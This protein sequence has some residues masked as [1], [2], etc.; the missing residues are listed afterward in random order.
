MFAFIIHHIKLVLTRADFHRKRRASHSLTSTRTHWTSVEKASH[1]LTSTILTSTRTSSHSLTSTHILGWKVSCWNGCFLCP[2]S[3]LA[4][5]S[6]EIPW[7]KRPKVETF[8]SRSNG[9]HH[10]PPMTV[11]SLD[12]H[13]VPTNLHDKC[14]YCMYINI[15]I[16][17]TLYICK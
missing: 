5:L 7:L 15:Y 16:Y 2:D 8:G 4:D 6:G 13:C 10:V 9:H 3:E 1:S 12:V 17:I 11:E 14:I